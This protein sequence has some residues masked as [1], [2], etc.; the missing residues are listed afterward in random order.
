L[1]VLAALLLLFGGAGHYLEAQ[2][3][4]AAGRIARLSAG[5]TIPVGSIPV[6]LHRLGQASQ[7][8][9]DTVA[10]DTR[11][12][13]QVRFVPDSGALFLL[14]VRYQ[15]IEYFS[16]PIRGEAGRPDTALLLIVADTSSEVVVRVAERTVLIGRPDASGSRQVID[17]LVLENSSERTRV[18]SDSSR[19]S[20][21][22]P[23]P[24]DA[25]DV[26]LADIHLSQFSPDAV[27]FRRDSVM[28][29][30]PLSPGRK[31]LVLQYRIPG[32]ARRFEA[33]ARG[34]DS[35]FVLLEDPGARIEEPRLTRASS[36]RVEGRAF[37]R[38][39]GVLGEAR[40][41]AVTFPSP[42]IAPGTLL[43]VLLG[44]T[45]TGFLGLGIFLLRK[46]RVA[47]FLPDPIGL[48]D[49]IARMDEQAAEA[50]ENLSDEQR[51]AWE[52]ERA[53]LKS[54]LVRALAASRRRS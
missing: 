52:T 4:R 53:R 10:A 28:V 5:D 20:F 42:G 47:A 51:Q 27:S 34:T 1:K 23:L 49:A 9:V 22:V 3:A 54:L 38:W 26:Q 21:G 7:G 29:F 11:G 8:P 33:P 19:P 30:A 37:T 17:W 32:S 45:V 31:E 46:R 18:A 41:I 40:Q 15:G 39:A 16:S 24:G 36:Q 25:Q 13:F 48:A 43:V 35:V 2:Q 12:R 14:S 50:G 6:V 44:V